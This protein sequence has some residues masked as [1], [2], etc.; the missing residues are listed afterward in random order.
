MSPWWYIVIVPAGIFALAF[1]YVWCQIIFF[2]VHGGTIKI[3]QL[4]E[5][6]EEVIDR[7]RHD[8]TLIIRRP[9]LQE[10]LV[11]IHIEGAKLQVDACRLVFSKR[12]VSN[13][14]V[15]LDEDAGR[16]G[17]VPGTTACLERDHYNYI[18]T[19]KN[20]SN[21]MLS[22]ASAIADLI[23]N[24]FGPFDEHDHLHYKVKF[25]IK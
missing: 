8:R 22:Y 20:H 3:N 5:H 4:T 17:T 23:I 21:D 10:D 13:P 9:G 11:T 2:R 15:Y 18:V 7:E 6:L 24:L 25:T 14:G 16:I 19:F 12:L 1:M